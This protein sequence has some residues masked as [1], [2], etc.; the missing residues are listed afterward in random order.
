MHEHGVVPLLIG[1]VGSSDP[2]VQ[3]QSASCLKNIRT[4]A[5]FNEKVKYNPA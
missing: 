1:F 5:L 3:T 2:D 4:L